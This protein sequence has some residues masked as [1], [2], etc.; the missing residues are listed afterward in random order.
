MVKKI[1]NF[2]KDIKEI[3]SLLFF[4]QTSAENLNKT[5]SNSRKSMKHFVSRLAQRK[6]NQNE[7]RH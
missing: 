1:L 6:K 4:K 3:T 7:N 2:D 5:N